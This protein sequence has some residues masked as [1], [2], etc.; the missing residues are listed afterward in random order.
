MLKGEKDGIKINNSSSEEDG[1]EDE[2]AVLLNEDVENEFI[3]VL[4]KIRNKHPDIYNKE[5]KFFEGKN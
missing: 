3:S 5:K 4:A 1:P 2:N